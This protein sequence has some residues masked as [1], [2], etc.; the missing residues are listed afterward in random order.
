MQD[1]QHHPTKPTARESGAARR[2]AE[3]RCEQ[4]CI[5][6]GRRAAPRAAPKGI[7]VLARQGWEPSLGA[8]PSSFTNNNPRC[9]DKTTLGTFQKITAF[10]AGNFCTA[11]P[12]RPRGS[13]GTAHPSSRR[14]SRCCTRFHHLRYSTAF[15]CRMR[16]LAAG[17]LSGATALCLWKNTSTAFHSPG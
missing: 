10:I 14:S 11:T 17:D 16:F 7:A 12:P 2:V 1:E 8:Q 6:C 13:R 15:L 4:G 5:P 9:E 3:P